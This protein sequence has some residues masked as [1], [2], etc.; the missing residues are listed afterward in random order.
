M[1]AFLAYFVLS[2]RFGGRTLGMMICGI[3]LVHLPTGSQRLTWGG[4]LLR[5]VVL[6]AGFIC[7]VTVLV[8][9]VITAA[10][11]TK[12]GPHDLAARTGVLGRRPQ[13]L[14]VPQASESVF[15]TVAVVADQSKAPSP[16]AVETAAPVKDV[17]FISHATPDGDIARRLSD[18]LEAEGLHTWLASRDVAVGANYAA[19]IVRAVSS[20]QY[21]LV[22]LSPASIESPHVRR[23]VSIA[24]DRKVQVLPV[25]TDPTGQFMAELPV[26]WTYWLSL[27]QVL[28]MSDEQATAREISKRIARPV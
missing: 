20:A 17:I 19:E 24:I 18:A 6:G 27:A 10:S 16:G 13:A 4:A 23:E 11:R 5:A 12:Q 26:D 9:L 22:I 15:P 28:R 2:Y 3:A 25:S 1:A 8:W 14:S 7:G 21:L